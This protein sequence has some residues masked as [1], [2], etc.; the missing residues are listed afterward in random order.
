L[1]KTTFPDWDWMIKLQINQSFTKRSRTK[2]KN[3]K[4]KDRSKNPYKSKDN[5]EF[6]MT[7]VNFKWKRKRREEKKNESIVD[8]KLCHHWLHTL[9]QKE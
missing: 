4:N 1:I 2:I 3:Q 7:S 8:N 6:C 5:H 9:P